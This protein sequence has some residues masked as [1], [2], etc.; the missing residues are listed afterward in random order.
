MQQNLGSVKRNEPRRREKKRK[1]LKKEKRMISTGIVVV[2]NFTFD[3]LKE[4]RQPGGPPLFCSVGLQSLDIPSV[5][6]SNICKDYPLNR[7]PDNVIGHWRIRDKC[8]TFEI[9]E[10]SNGR[11]LLLLERGY[12]IE[13]LAQLDSILEK[14]RGIIVN[15]VIGEVSWGDLQRLGKLS[16]P[17][18]LDIQ[19]FIRYYDKLS[20]KIL[21]YNPGFVGTPKNIL[22]VHG[23]DEEFRSISVSPEDLLRL[24]VGEV[25]Y[26]KGKEGFQVITKDGKELFPPRH[27]GN[28]VVGTGDFLL[29]VYFSL[30]IDGNT[31]RE[32][33]EKSRELVEEFVLSSMVNN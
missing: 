31:I 25:L 33:G 5:T 9:E 21:F 11:D 18:A 4:R 12:D 2:G 32:A 14:S 7:L 1:K 27:T 22:V 23:S 6:V 8:T 20:N 15:P 10:T 29:S 26:T 17:I 16:R 19:G 30:R 24:G 28:N 3:V 13:H